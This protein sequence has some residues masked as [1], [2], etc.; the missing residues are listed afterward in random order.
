MPVK[1]VCELSDL[2][3]DFPI[4]AKMIL[5]VNINVKANEHGL[6]TVKYMAEKEVTSDILM[7]ASEADVKLS[8][9]GKVIF[10]GVCMSVR[11]QKGFEYSEVEITAISHSVKADREPHWR[12]FQDE[13][14]KISD[15]ASVVLK[16]CGGSLTIKPDVSIPEIVIQQDETDFEFLKRIINYN[17]MNLY[18][19]VNGTKVDLIAGKDTKFQSRSLKSDETDVYKQRKNI[20]EYARFKG[21]SDNDASACDALEDFCVVNNMDW[22]AGD[23]VSGSPEKVIVENIAESDGG[24]L[25]NKI[26]MRPKAGG[27][28]NYV[29]KRDILPACLEAKV[30]KVQQGDNQVKVQFL[31]DDKQ[32]EA[33][34]MWID[35]EH[36]MS[37]YAYIMPDEGDHV[38]VYFSFNKKPVARNSRRMGENDK[39]SNY[40][41][42]KKE[43]LP[44]TKMLTSHNKMLRFTPKGLELVSDK[45]NYVKG[46]SLLQL[47]DDK[48]VRFSSEKDICIKGKSI[49]LD[50]A[51]KCNII[52]KSGV[53][54]KVGGSAVKMK[55]SDISLK[56][57][58]LKHMAMIP[59]A[60][61]GSG[62]GGEVSEKDDFDSDKVMNFPSLT[63][64]EKS[65]S[66]ASTLKKGG[67]G[68]NVSSGSLKS[69]KDEKAKAVNYKADKVKS[70]SWKIAFGALKNLKA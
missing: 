48:G 23:V 42:I 33:K 27:V 60:M 52:G 57:S 68:G 56:T 55:G 4:V 49:K 46:G 63:Y 64:K 28:P 41:D 3:L 61:G 2:K 62:K 14:K 39:D 20:L 58:S 18:V 5:D 65:I 70:P 13:A 44:T 38:W 1:G 37:N 36:S 30:L 22:Q 59:K 10:A 67:S 16:D 35:Y 21:M 50:A 11:A 32:D 25:R 6:M 26:I 31:I 51:S 66:T 19:A 54:I 43:Y 69:A 40:N 12:S 15:I 17:K 7:S 53:T 45:K 24:V 47:D 8:C 29:D 9:D 34:A